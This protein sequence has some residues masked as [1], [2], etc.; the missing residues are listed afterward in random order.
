MV[1][2]GKG[3]ARACWGEEAWVYAEL[4]YISEVKGY[5]VIVFQ[6]LEAPK[7]NVINDPHRIHRSQ[8]PLFWKQWRRKGSCPPTSTVVGKQSLE[9]TIYWQEDSDPENKNFYEKNPDSHGYDKDPVLDIWNTQPVFFFGV[10][11][12]L[13][14]GSTFVAYLPD[15]RMQEWACCEAG[16]LV[17][18]Q[19]PKAFPSWNPTASTPARSSCQRMRTDQ[20]LSGAQEAPPSPPLACHSDLIQGLK[21]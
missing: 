3:K 4:P 20:L 7:E 19:E 5:H 16:R 9:L 13:A 18:Y 11:V 6:R 14:L 17:K 15:Y 1:M 10:S 2:Q 8:R 12:V 21:V